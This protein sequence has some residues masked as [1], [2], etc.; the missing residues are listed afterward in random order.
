VC[1]EDSTKYKCPGCQARTC[2]LACCEKHKQ[3]SGCSGRR[4][5]LAYVKLKEF[6]DKALM[7]GMAR[8]LVSRTA[9]PHTPTQPHHVSQPC[10]CASSRALLPAPTAATYALQHPAP[11]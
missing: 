9:A 5:R 2:S 1:N 6:D 10:G 11:S 7:S 4:D 8:G 3:D